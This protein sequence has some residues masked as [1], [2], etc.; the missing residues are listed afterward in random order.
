MAN[1]STGSSS[2]HTSAVDQTTS[3]YQRF[4]LLLL[5]FCAGVA[6][7]GLEMT[8]SQIIRPYFGSTISVWTSLIGLV[9]IFLTAGYYL[10]GA[11]ADRRPSRGMLGM[12]VLVAGVALLVVPLISNRVLQS[13]WLASPKLGI[14]GGSMLATFALFA[15]PNIILGC[16]CPFAMKLSIADLGRTGRSAGNIYA[17]SAVGSVVG[18]FL[19]ALFMIETFGARHS[20]MIFGALLIATSLLL[21]ARAR[22]TPAVA[23]LALFWV[24]LQ[25]MLPVQKAIAERES[26]YNYLQV[27]DTG[28]PRLLIVDWGAFSF[29]IPGV[30]R[31]GTYYDYLLLA[32]L[33]RPQ[34][35]AQWLHRSLVIG[36]GAG[37]ISKQT[38]Q[39]FGPIPI[40]GV[41]ID[42]AIVALGRKYF[43]MHEKNLHVHETDGRTFLAGA[44]KPYDWIV[45]DAYQGSDIPAHLVTKEF[46]ALL[47]QHMTPN[48]VLSINVAWW[49]A[50]DTELLRRLMTTVRTAFPHVYAITGIGK[51]S[52]VVLAGGEDT[53][54]ERIVTNAKLTRHAGLIQIA[55]EL[56]SGTGAHFENPPSLGAPYT[57]DRAA[58]DKIVDRMY[59]KA[60][61][62]KEC[63]ARERKVLGL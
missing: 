26:P 28:G 41:E 5:V 10:G 45:V 52:A 58:V 55:Q 53:L 23:T 35:P 32:P 62:N 2:A 39:C 54:P 22:W 31:T 56:Q 18:T 7:M 21:L 34:P 44:G 38:T 36:L 6:V 43:D 12:L 30:F 3:T 1:L 17:I 27:V 48:A 61:T 11:L 8:A 59:M 49:E 19:P 50:D 9:M 37:T 16:V 15:V 40:D 47:R 51:T 60:R 4:S 42:P 25:P 46:F 14:L 33:M 20:I 63:F 29:Y 57:D 13:V 24:P